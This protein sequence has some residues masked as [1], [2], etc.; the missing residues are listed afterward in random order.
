LPIADY[1]RLLMAVVFLVWADDG[2]WQGF[3]Q[4]GIKPAA[5]E[6]LL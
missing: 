3:D 6:F 4:A 1:P 2:C 5:Q